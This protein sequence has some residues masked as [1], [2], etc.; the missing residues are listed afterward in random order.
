[1]EEDEFEEFGSG[2]DARCGGRH[3]GCGVI[4]VILI[5]RSKRMFTHLNLGVRFVEWMPK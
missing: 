1:M 2:E 5:E 3:C 4:V